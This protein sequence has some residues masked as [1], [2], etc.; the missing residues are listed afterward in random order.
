MGNSSRNCDF[1]ST[2]LEHEEEL[3][4]LA[5]AYPGASED[6]PWGECAFKVRK[7]VFL[8]VSL[9]E[10]GLGTSVKLP[11]GAEEALLLPFS[12]PTGYGLGKHGWVS[13]RFPLGSQPPMFILAR[14]IEESYRSVA[15]KK[16]VLE[17][18]RSG[19]AN[20]ARPRKKA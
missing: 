17:L 10:K 9:T 7:K 19:A 2:D 11:S 13:A 4:S 14:W 12:E 15:P 8:F 16:L 18:D 20:R 6:H 5:M 3:R 1:D